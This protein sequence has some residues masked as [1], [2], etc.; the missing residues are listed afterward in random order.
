MNRK[1]QKY[2]ALAI[3][4]IDLA[5]KHKLY[6]LAES[7]F[8]NATDCSYPDDPNGWN[9][10]GYWE[11]VYTSIASNIDSHNLEHNLELK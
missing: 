7:G 4:L 8:R 6:W 11:F 5:V 10:G 1:E 2:K 9:G 3:D